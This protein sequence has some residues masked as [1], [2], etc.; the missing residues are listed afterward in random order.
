MPANILNNTQK[1]YNYKRFKVW[2]ETTPVE[3]DLRKEYEELCLAEIGALK[4]DFKIVKEREDKLHRGGRSDKILYYSDGITRLEWILEALK[5]VLFLAE[6][7][8][9]KKEAETELKKYHTARLK[10][11]DQW[12][13]DPSQEHWQ[14]EFEEEIKSFRASE[15]YN[16]L[17]YP[18]EADFA[19]VWKWSELPEHPFVTA[20]RK[21]EDG[22]SFYIFF[23]RMR[24]PFRNLAWFIKESLLNFFKK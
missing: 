14:H 17:K 19:N 6:A 16:F 24:Y 4:N 18:S 9:L 12:L 23:C 11:L 21:T 1:G 5:L 22:L 2:L 20:L 10:L 15:Q 7:R 13:N 8:D 3:H